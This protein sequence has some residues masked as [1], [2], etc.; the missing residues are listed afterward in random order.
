MKA[1]SDSVWNVTT[2]SADETRRLGETLGRALHGG[3]A[4]LLIGQL[5]AGKTTFTQG[6]AVGLD[7]EAYTKSPSF[8][9]LHEHHGRVPLYHLDLF[10]IETVEEA[11]DLGLDEYLSGPGVVAVEWADRA[12]GAFPEDVIAV[13]IEAL[14]DD[15]RTFAMRAGGPLSMEALRRAET[16]SSG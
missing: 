4:V 13:E 12:R 16:G 9:L 8:V 10:R 2:E 6:L 7:V 15:K 3:E 11:W 5:G 14:T 1:A